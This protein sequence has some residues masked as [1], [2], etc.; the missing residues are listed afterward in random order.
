MN[1]SHSAAR[2]SFAVFCIVLLLCC[3]YAACVDIALSTDVVRTIKREVQSPDGHYTAV[4]FTVDAGATTS[5][6]HGVA[7]LKMPEDSGLSSY[8]GLCVYG[9]DIAPSITWSGIDTLEIAVFPNLEPYALTKTRLG[10]VTVT[11]VARKN[12]RLR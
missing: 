2:I 7:I 10:D 3:L 6:G 12:S 1:R 9:S 5:T 8:S 11:Y 4:H